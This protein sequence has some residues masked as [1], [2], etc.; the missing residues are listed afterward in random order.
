MNAIHN[1]VSQIGSLY[2]LLIYD[3]FRCFIRCGNVKINRKIQH[4]IYR[5]PITQQIKN[6]QNK[7]LND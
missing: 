5:L 1:I 2:I 6:I 4:F 3:T 7:S